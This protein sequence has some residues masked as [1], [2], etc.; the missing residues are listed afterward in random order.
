M[1]ND[2]I[3]KL[4]TKKELEYKI[5]QYKEKLRKFKAKK[6]YQ[7]IAPIYYDLG[8]LYEIL[9][10]EEAS[11]DC[12]QKIVDKWNAYPDEVPY[13]ICVNALEL[14][15]RPYEA[16][17]IVLTYPRNWNLRT[18]AHFYEQLGRKKEAILL[19]AGL[20]YYFY[21]LSEAYYPFWQPHYLQE[22]ADLCERAGLFERSRIYTQGAVVSWDQMKNNIGKPLHFIEK[23][24]LYEEI[25]Y[26]YER[27]G[28]LETAMEYYRKT[29]IE[30]KEAYTK[31]I[32]STEANQ[33][34]GDWGEYWEFFTQQISD[35]RLIH[36]YFDSSEENDY[37][38]IK[39]RILNLEEQMKINHEYYYN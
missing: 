36:F 1:K 32:K 4:Y 25:G 14:L 26:I 39:Y 38:R 6:D 31:D 18:L 3:K 29:K 28:K 12:Y 8:C 23:A 19:F 11:K 24:W 22:G 37:R 10:K 33:I 9:K 16:L 13:H 27:F 20:S 5:D 17:Q 35:I 21:K 15:E 30:Y 34:N 7:I 2:I